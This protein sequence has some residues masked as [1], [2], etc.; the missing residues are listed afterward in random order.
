[1]NGLKKLFGTAAI[2]AAIGLGAGVT[3]AQEAEKPVEST[4]ETETNVSITGAKKATSETTN[5]FYVPVEGDRV[6]ITAENAADVYGGIKCE[7]KDLVADHSPRTQ[8][9]DN[10]L[11]HFDDYQWVVLPVE[12]GLELCHDA[13]ENGRCETTESRVNSPEGET[14]FTNLGTIVAEKVAATPG[15]TGVKVEKIER[16]SFQ[17]PGNK[18]LEEVI[19][20]STVARTTDLVYVGFVGQYDTDN[21]VF[22]P[23]GVVGYNR[24]TNST[25]VWGLELGFLGKNYT[26]DDSKDPVETALGTLHTDG[27]KEIQ[28]KYFAAKVNMG[29]MFK[30]FGILGSAGYQVGFGKEGKSRHEEIRDSNGT[31]LE[32]YQHNDNQ[33]PEK[34]NTTHALLFGIDVPIKLSEKLC[35]APYIGAATDFN[36][37]DPQF[38]IKLGYCPVEKEE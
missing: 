35:L 11:G 13:N 15:N 7:I 32:T 12:K 37:I 8:N 24:V 5:L 21:N 4:V 3:S 28:Q 20:P 25:F 34:M 31:V 2:A 16:Q 14:V 36:K 9:M 26:L 22:V 27:E 23:G 38:W 18:T 17:V 19:A 29:K 30:K 6:E 33:S 10:F 1:M